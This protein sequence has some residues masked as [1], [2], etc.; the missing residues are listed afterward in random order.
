MGRRGRRK[1]TLNGFTQPGHWTHTQQSFDAYKSCLKMPRQS[2]EARRLAGDQ[3]SGDIALQMARRG[4]RK[5]AV[6]AQLGARESW[7]AGATLVHVRLNEGHAWEER[8][9]KSC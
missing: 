6:Q 2:W 5:R 1:A 4:Q 8:N 7:T 9:N 3:R